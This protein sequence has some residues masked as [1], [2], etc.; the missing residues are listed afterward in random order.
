MRPLVP[1]HIRPAAHALGRRRAQAH[2]TE[3]PTNEVASADSCRQLHEFSALPLQADASLAVWRLA[4]PWA[5]IVGDLPGLGPALACTAN[6][7]A[8]LARSGPCAP[9]LPAS[10]F[11]EGLGLVHGE[12]L[13]LRLCFARWAH[14]FALARR[15]ADGAVQRSLVFFDAHGDR[16]HAL[17][18]APGSDGQ[19]FQSLLD[20]HA[21]PAARRTREASPIVLA[22]RPQRSAELPDAR[23]DLRACHEAWRSMRHPH[24]FTA[25][26]QAFGLGRLQALRLAPPGHAQ[27]LGPSSAHEALAHAAQLGVPLVVTVGNHG[28]S[29][30]HTGHLPHVDMQGSR[31][32]A[33][34]HGSHLSLDEAAIDTAWLVRRPSTAGLQQSLECF[35]AHGGL[36]AMLSGARSPGHARLC[37]WQ[38]VLGALQTE[39]AVLPG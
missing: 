11:A 20:R 21:V 27:P 32:R 26:M 35:D 1:P 28:A 13:T 15:L 6:A 29:H 34:G 39:P 16:A 24:D 25:L 4:S 22:P 14:G 17:Q 8:S 3:A 19:A 37:A 12:G 38:Q 7:H 10:A 33:Q 31:V 36:I 5:H 23:I 30:T 2:P 9:L 18:L